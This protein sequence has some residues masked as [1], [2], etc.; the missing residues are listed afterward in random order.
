MIEM[1]HIRKRIQ[2]HVPRQLA[3]MDLVRAAVLIPIV[4]SEDNL[5]ILLTVRTDE[6]E[7]HKGQVAFPGGAVEPQD[8]DVRETALRETREEIALTPDQIEVIGRI[9]DLWTPTGFIVSPFI[10][11]VPML[12]ELTMEPGEV[13]D[14]FTVPL[15]FF[16]HDANGY[17]K[18]YPRGDTEV[19]VWFYEYNSY[20]VWGVTAFI[21]RNLK[22]ILE[23]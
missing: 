20:K 13:S 10:G 11:Y 1:N 7:H 17:T 21:I 18:K 14:Y 8:A 22:S 16:M 2:N 5:E 3:A 15:D 19:D 23:P 12:P 9:D 6:V 4:E